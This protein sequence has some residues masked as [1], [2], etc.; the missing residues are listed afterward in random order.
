MLYRE[1]APVSKEAWKEIDERAK[2][3]L[4]LICRREKWSE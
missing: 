1:I 4:K 3:F 2:K